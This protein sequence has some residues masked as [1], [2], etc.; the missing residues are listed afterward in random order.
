MV[1]IWVIVFLGWRESNI[2]IMLGGAPS[3]SNPPTSHA[4]GHQP[5]SLTWI[6]SRQPTDLGGDATMPLR[7]KLN[8]H[9]FH[10][11]NGSFRNVRA[12]QITINQCK[13]SKIRPLC[14]MKPFESYGFGDPPFLPNTSF[15]YINVR[16]HA[17]CSKMNLL[18]PTGVDS[19]IWGFP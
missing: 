13:S 18:R 16:W 6:E 1:R 12:T 8:P 15:V 5:G 7:W 14:Y 4:S 3:Y 2:A 9:I 19:S 11:A 17:I 10:G